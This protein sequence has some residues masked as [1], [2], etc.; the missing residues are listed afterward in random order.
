MSTFW[1]LLRA[2]FSRAAS[3]EGGKLSTPMTRSAMP[4]R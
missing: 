3:T 2:R 4:A 1:M